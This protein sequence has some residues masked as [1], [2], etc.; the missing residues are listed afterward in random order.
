[1]ARTVADLSVS[2]AI[3]RPR[4]VSDQ[5]QRNVPE[6]LPS[7]SQFCELRPLIFVAPWWLPRNDVASRMARK[8]IHR[9]MP[10][11]DVE[12]CPRSSATANQRDALSPLIVGEYPR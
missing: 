8:N 2:F 9:M 5:P 10:I 12:Y 7:V 4:V 6:Q 1:M 11:P 3:P